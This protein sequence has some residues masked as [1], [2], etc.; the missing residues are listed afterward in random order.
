MA[1]I[2]VVMPQMGE[3]IA[4]GTIVK[5]HKN[6]GDAVR[7]DEIL[8]EISTDKVDS[9][10]PSPAAGILVEIVVKEQ[11]TVAVQTVVAYLET[12]EA[13]AAG[14]QAH[15]GAAVQ[16]EDPASAQSA[17]APSAGANAGTTS[18]G[19]GAAAHA[20]ASA[21]VT[22]PG[23]AHVLGPPAAPTDASRLRDR[24]YSPLVLSIAR[25]EQVSMD[26]LEQIS[27]SGE[28]GRVTKKDI[29][30]YVNAKKSGQVAPVASRAPAALSSHS[31]GAPASHM[32]VGP[33][34]AK[35]PL[36]RGQGD[37]VIPMTNVQ[38]KM[39]QH[40]VASMQTSPH[41][42]AI[43]EV[44][45]TVIVKHRSD[46]AAAFE[47]SEG[48]KLTYTPYIIDAVVRAIK[49]YPLINASV[50]GT[51]IVRKSAINIGM[52]VASENGLIVPVIKHAEE[53]SLLGIARA[54]H[55]LAERTR[56]R[57]LM[58]DDIQGGTFTLSNYGVFGTV[59]GTPI[60]NQPQ[61]AILGTGA[62][63][64]RPVVI[65]EAIAIRSIAY[66]TLSFDHRVVDGM[67]GGMFMDSIVKNL[68]GF[69]AAGEI[70]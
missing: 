45:M 59:F 6:V 67:L 15:T 49:K 10:I 39:A 25:T 32:P 17:G 24:F 61:I 56:A 11:A 8:L 57:K 13:L 22:G 12:D 4:E 50:E 33:A 26:E 41:V 14:Q 46:H 48:F 53:K 42:A 55:D 68:E 47:R 51:S 29:L 19:A 66:F 36:A 65:N 38:Q 37:Q 28:G 18:S 52:A 34:S 2:E 43:H 62:I 30:G 60:I 21:P 31:P 63:V 9:E 16:G 7:K 1:R 35:A 20:D 69:D 44:D 5:W 3:S 70:K 27:G 58:P 40:M 54:V 64:K 23:P